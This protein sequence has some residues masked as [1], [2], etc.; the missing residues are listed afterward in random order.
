MRGV[1]DLDA[2]QAEEKL[3]VYLSTIVM[4]KF[5]KNQGS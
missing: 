5:L 3:E 4:G 2:K 1:G